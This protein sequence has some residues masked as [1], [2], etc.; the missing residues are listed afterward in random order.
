MFTLNDITDVVRAYPVI[1][2]NGLHDKT[3]LLLDHNLVRMVNQSAKWIEHGK[4]ATKDTARRSS[5]GLKHR[6]ER[7][8]TVVEE[9]PTYISNSAFIIAALLMGWSFRV[10]KNVPLDCLNAFF[11]KSAAHA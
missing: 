5:Y 8:C 6:A 11:K 9:T 7:W 3:P 10:P 1:G 2:C 4:D